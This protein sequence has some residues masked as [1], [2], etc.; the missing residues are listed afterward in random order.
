MTGTATHVSW[1]T[2]ILRGWPTRALALAFLAYASCVPV[3]PV[4][5]ANVCEVDADCH[6]GACNVELGMCVTNAREPLQIILE[7]TP[8][9]DLAGG[10]GLTLAYDPMTIDGPQQLDLSV[11]SGIPTS[12]RVWDATTGAEVDA[13]VT[14]RLESPIAG[15]PSSSVVADVGDVQSDSEYRYNFATR[16]LPERA[17]S[18]EVNP[19]GELRATLPPL[20]IGQL[21]TS[22]AGSTVRIPDVLVYPR[23]CAA[24]ALDDPFNAE[25]CLV[26][27]PGLV[28]DA[29]GAPQS[30]M[31]VRAIETA[32]GRVI[33]SVN[34]TGDDGAFDSV[35]ELAYW[36]DATR[37]HFRITPSTER[38]AMNGPSPTFTVE[39]ASL[40][41]G[42]ERVRILTPRVA[43]R[44][45][46]EGTVEAASSPGEGLPNATLSFESRDVFDASSGVLGV[47]GASTA[48]DDAG[49]FSIELIPGTYEVVIVPDRALS[50]EFSIIGEQRDLTTA[51]GDLRGQVFQVPERTRFGGTIQTSAGEPVVDARIRAEARQEV[52]DELDPLAQFARPVEVMSGATG[53]FDLRLDVGYYDVT[54]VPPARSNYPWVLA[55]DVA[56]GGASA[57][58]SAVYEVETPVTLSGVASFDRDGTRVP[59]TGGT[60]RA[61]A[62]IG[63]D[64]ERAVLIGESTVG[65]DGH[66]TLLLPPAL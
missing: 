22:Q 45:L 39:P 25:P 48:T 24:S 21:M 20:R 2:T 37:W 54:I 62:V 19:V 53:V 59:V 28:V 36:R 26:T 52:P 51:S 49:H 31:I 35:M 41:P 14:F 32:T 6:A 9:S 13:Q 56:I 23:Q 46:Y 42:T 3:E 65:A 64:A 34:Q 4:G 30:S 17:Y 11:P 27:V 60:L 38:V 10:P 43:A 50:G 12:G 66:Y 47:F 7:V 44:V 16:L 58:F 29:D 33:S 1:S 5:P 15:V 61:Y 18:V 57:P 63:G 55:R 40:F 8:D